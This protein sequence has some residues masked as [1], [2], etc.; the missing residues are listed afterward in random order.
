MNPLENSFETILVLSIDYDNCG[1]I[2]SEEQLLGRLAGKRYLP[3]KDP[4][5]GTPVG[6]YTKTANECPNLA[7]AIKICRQVLYQA[8][9]G[10]RAKYKDIE[11]Y[12]GSNRQDLQLDKMNAKANLNGSCFFVFQRF[13]KE[14]NIKFNTLLYADIENKQQKPQAMTD[15]SLECTFSEKKDKIIL[16]QLENI[17]HSYPDKQ[18]EFVF[19]DDDDKNKIISS[20]KMAIKKAYQDEQRSKKLPQHIKITLYKYDCFK[21][22]EQALEKSNKKN[23]LDYAQ[24]QLITKYSLSYHNGQE[25]KK[26][27]PLSSGC[28]SFWK[29]FT[30]GTKKVPISDNQQPNLPKNPS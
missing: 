3:F 7:G 8:M 15:A 19:I 6:A 1:V 24:K 16:A 28:S 23:L 17:A 14:N 9:L 20:L 30:C 12:V 5:Y 10:N 13:A 11:L 22:L 27:A 25:I 29:I 21:V 2:L 18:I 4:N 26:Q